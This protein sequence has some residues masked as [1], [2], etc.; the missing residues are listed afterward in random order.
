MRRKDE[1]M[2]KPVSQKRQALKEK[3]Q[4]KKRK[5]RK[6]SEKYRE[7]RRNENEICLI[8]IIDREHQKGKWPPKC[9]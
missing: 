7:N 9:R 1:Q 3:K 4:I 8:L 5:K 2:S 6:S